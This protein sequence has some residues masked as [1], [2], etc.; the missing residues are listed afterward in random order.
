MGASYSMI[1]KL[2]PDG[3]VSTYC[4]TSTPTSAYGACSTVSAYSR[5][6]VAVGNDGTIYF[7]DGGGLSK[8]LK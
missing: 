7:A 1:R 3:T 4:G 6:G 8:I 2:A 5:F